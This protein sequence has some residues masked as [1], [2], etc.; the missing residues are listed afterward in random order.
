MQRHGTNLRTACEEERMLRIEVSPL[1]GH[2]RVQDVTRRDVADLVHRVADRLR[3]QGRHGTNANRLL[4]VCKRL[5]GRAVA[6]GWLE[7]SPAD[8]IDKPVEEQQRSRVLDD[9]E[10]ARAWSAFE[11]LD[12]RFRD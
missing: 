2:K 9:A 11:L 6:W 10:I 12:E 5:F 7:Y 3:T 4:S 1:L 8:R